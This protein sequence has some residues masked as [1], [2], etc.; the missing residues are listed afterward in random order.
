MEWWLTL[1][2]IWLCLDIMILAVIVGGIRLIKPHCPTWWK[3]AIVDDEPET[4][5]FGR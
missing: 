4:F 2:I 1:I 5:D 3:R